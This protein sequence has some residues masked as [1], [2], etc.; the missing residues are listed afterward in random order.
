MAIR[1]L[2]KERERERESKR[3]VGAV[4][5]ETLIFEGKGNKG[6]RV[7]SEGSGALRFGLNWKSGGSGCLDSG[8]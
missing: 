6:S 7:E 8:G 1:G 2:Q 4:R 5:G 3:K